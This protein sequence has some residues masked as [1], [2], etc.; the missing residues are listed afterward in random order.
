VRGW[1]S[2]CINE[3]IAP[4]L[5]N[6]SRPEMAVLL[7]AASVQKEIVA[8]HS[9]KMTLAKWLGYKMP[10]IVRTP[11][12]RRQ[13]IR[14]TIRRHSSLSPM[15]KASRKPLKTRVVSVVCL[16]RT[17]VEFLCMICIAS[18]R[19]L[20]ADLCAVVCVLCLSSVFYVLCSVF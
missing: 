2:L 12:Q 8:L 13:M 19:A 1:F 18:V 10:L 7:L 6:S 9:K 16:E 17:Q 11:N 15:S 4:K 3:I 20:G 14:E 5:D